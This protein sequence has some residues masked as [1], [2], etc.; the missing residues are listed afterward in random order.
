MLPIAN[1]SGE[2]YLNMESVKRNL[3][4][5]TQSVQILRG[6]ITVTPVGVVVEAG[7]SRDKV[8]AIETKTIELEK[9][10]TGMETG[11]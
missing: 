1:L 9:I 2:K 11:R 3:Q 10:L 4:D 7:W 8:K 5:Y 6:S